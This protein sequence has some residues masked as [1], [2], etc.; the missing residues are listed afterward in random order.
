M[1]RWHETAR[2]SIIGDCP[3]G[4]DVSLPSDGSRREIGG[5]LMLLSLAI[6]ALCAA[7]VIW[8]CAP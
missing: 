3:D 4:M 6:V 2:D 5:R 8:G 7:A 1:T